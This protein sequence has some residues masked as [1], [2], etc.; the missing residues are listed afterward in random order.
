M[1]SLRNIS[2]H[3]HS[4][5]YTR[6]SFFMDLWY[7]ASNNNK[8]LSRMRVRTNTYTPST[9][10]R[11]KTGTLHGLYSEAKAVVSRQS[12]PTM[13]PVE[14]FCWRE[15]SKNSLRL[16]LLMMP[17]HSLHACHNGSVMCVCHFSLIGRDAVVVTSFFTKT[18]RKR[19]SMPRSSTIS[20]I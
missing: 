6:G 7:G 2:S 16:L 17:S 4:L 1:F 8:K 20:S 12:I 9:I 11:K 18:T 15:G 13:A 19:I 3:T 14:I 10:K 5:T